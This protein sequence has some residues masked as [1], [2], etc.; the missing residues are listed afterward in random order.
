MRGQRAPCV[1]SPASLGADALSPLRISRHSPRPLPWKPSAGFCSSGWHLA[2]EAASEAHMARSVQCRLTTMGWASSRSAIAFYRNMMLRVLEIS[3]FSSRNTRLSYFSPFP[4][5]FFL[6]D[7]LSMHPFFLIWDIPSLT[8]WSINNKKTCRP[9]V[10]IWGS[11]FWLWSDTAHC[12]QHIAFCCIFL[13]YT[14]STVL[15][16]PVWPATENQFTQI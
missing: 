13:T 9:I 14:V 5:P 10:Y 16:F 8:A 1:T 11:A 2:V 3:G 6:F 12:R 4:P 15:E 7:V